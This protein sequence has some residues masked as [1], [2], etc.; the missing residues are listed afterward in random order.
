MIRKSVKPTKA[1]K[2]RLYPN[3]EQR[4]MLNKTFGCV[5][6]YYNQALYDADTSYQITGKTEIKTPAKYKTGDR[7]WLREVDSVALSFTQIYL[8][9]AFTD[10]YRNPKHFRH[11]KF[12]S[13]KDTRK[14]YT[15][16]G[17]SIKL[18]GNRIYLPKI[19]LVKL[20]LHRAL[21]ENCKI[22]HV[23]VSLDPSFHYYVSIT[24]E[25]E[26]QVDKVTEINKAIGLDFSC[27]TLY[28]T[29][30]SD[31]LDFPGFVVHSREKLIRAQRKLSHM[32]RGS[33]NYHKQRRRLARIHNKIANQ[34]KDWLHKQTKVISDNYDLVCLET[35]NFQEISSEYG[36]AIGDE[37]A[38]MFVKFLSYKM[39]EKGKHLLLV[40]KYFPSS[41]LCNVCG[42]RNPDI[43]D[44][45][46][47]N[48]VCPNCNQKLDRDVNAARNILKE[49]LRIL[50]TATETKVRP[51]ITTNRGTHGGSSL[52]LTT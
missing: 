28:V 50:E 14:S 39:E 35:L 48:W 34:R 11:P 41:Q 3:K 19:G 5:R 26:N 47:R 45:S 36:R 7:I 37:G 32:K 20:V 43:K 27:K 46:I 40:D 18:K 52:I 10:F 12:K 13:K 9:K 21:P 23:T 16:T 29:S 38:G 2:Y 15:T 17:P 24:F 8:Q 49:G 51:K 4:V 22:K 42:Y 1:Y 44:L 25:Y 31:K 30:E 6:F 33:N